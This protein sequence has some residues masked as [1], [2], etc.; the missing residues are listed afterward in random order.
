MLSYGEFF[1]L[2]PLRKGDENDVDDLIPSQVDD[3]F[4]TLY[5]L[6]SFSIDDPPND[7]ALVSSGEEARRGVVPEPRDMLRL[8]V[9]SLAGD[10]LLLPID[11]RSSL[12]LF[13]KSYLAGEGLRVSLCFSLSMFRST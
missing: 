7:D 6:V 10:A 12:A 4:S 13:A 5:P 11:I 2:F 9:A 1:A 3:E 8:G